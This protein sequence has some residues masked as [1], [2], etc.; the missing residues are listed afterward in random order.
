MSREADPSYLEWVRLKG[1]SAKSAGQD[2][3]DLASSLI[4]S[5]YE[6]LSAAEASLSA[7]QRSFGTIPSSLSL[8]LPHPYPLSC[9]LLT[10]SIFLADCTRTRPKSPSP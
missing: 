5:L 8:S 2:V 6:K 9:P 1:S 10:L 4:D 7:S 3:V